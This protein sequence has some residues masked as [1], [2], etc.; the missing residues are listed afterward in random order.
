[1]IYQFKVGCRLTID[2]QTSGERLE[3]LRKKNDGRL[4]PEV[5]V[6]DAEED[7]SP[8]HPAFEWDDTV[9]AH[10]FRLD[11]ARHLSR[12]IVIIRDAQPDAKPIRAFV[13]ICHDGDDENSYT[14]IEVAMA[15]ESLRKQVLNAAMKEL[16]AFQNKYREYE[17]LVD[18]MSAIQKTEQRLAG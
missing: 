6:A 3:S 13:N 10:S 17:E 14:S 4:T 7:A 16:K 9:A 2:P 18:I 5:I 15:D 1:M 11:Q 12:S 8:L